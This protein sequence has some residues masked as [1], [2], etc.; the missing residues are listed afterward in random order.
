MPVPVFFNGDKIPDFFS[1]FNVGSWPFIA[2]AWHAIL[3]GVNGSELFRDTLGKLQITSPV[4]MDFDG[5]SNFDILSQV[6][7]HILTSSFADSFQTQLIVYDAKTGTTTPI[8][9]VVHGTNL[10]STPLVTDLDKD[11]KVDVI[12]TYMTDHVN[13]FS[14][15]H[16]VI[17]RLELDI[18]FTENPW[19]GV[20]GHRL[21]QCFS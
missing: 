2:I 5:D 19:G 15:K 3:S 6:N 12:Y 16:L 11:G 1:T 17:K 20:Y 18:K 7:I 14:Y 21:H 10:G 8:D 9:S 4:L 13:F